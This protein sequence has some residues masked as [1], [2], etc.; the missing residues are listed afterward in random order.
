MNDNDFL[1]CLHKLETEGVK[2]VGAKQI[3]EFINTLLSK[4]EKYQLLEN[5]V[6][7]D[8]NSIEHL[9][10][11]GRYIDELSLICEEF[12]CGEQGSLGSEL[13]FHFI[14]GKLY[15]TELVLCFYVLSNLEP[16]ILI[17]GQGVCIDV[18][19]KFQLGNEELS[20]INKDKIVN[21]ENEIINKTIK[22]LKL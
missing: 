11:D 3:K 13:V 14:E 9:V 16:K 15:Y 12:G 19:S 5:L 18:H 1:Q 8:C 6:I 21:I 17:E 22:Y 10:N 4:L 20:N 7:G 2:E